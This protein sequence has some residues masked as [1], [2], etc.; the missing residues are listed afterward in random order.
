MDERPER[1]ADYFLVVGL[2][3]R[4]TP[5]RHVEDGVEESFTIP[6]AVEEPVTDVVLVS[7]K[8]ESCPKG[9]Q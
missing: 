1:I 3:G 9:Y 8:H 7:K 5:L 2:G 4:P 6:V